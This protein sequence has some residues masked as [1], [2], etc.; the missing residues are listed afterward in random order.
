MGEFSLLVSMQQLREQSA[1]HMEPIRN[2]RLW[3]LHEQ[4]MTSQK[5]E[6]LL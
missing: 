3:G 2:V 6:M 4:Q 5:R 1:L